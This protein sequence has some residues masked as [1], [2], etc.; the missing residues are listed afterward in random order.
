[1]MAQLS[2]VETRS[3]GEV[4]RLRQHAE[5]LDRKCGEEVTAKRQLELDLKRK[6]ELDK[7]QWCRREAEL[8]H[9]KAALEQRLREEMDRTESLQTELI[10]VG[11]VLR[12]RLEES[13]SEAQGFKALARELNSA[14][15]TLNQSSLTANVVLMRQQLDHDNP[16][17]LEGPRNGSNILYS[18]VSPEQSAVTPEHSAELPV[19]HRRHPAS[20]RSVLSG[21]TSKSGSPAD[22]SRKNSPE[23]SSVRSAMYM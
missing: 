10:S 16:N 2:A 13:A 14:S 8:L 7:T 1:M 11:D 9:E 15:L 4:D 23:V 19:Q 21:M 20:G 22:P 18:R 5:A 12:S 3:R 17:I 6:L